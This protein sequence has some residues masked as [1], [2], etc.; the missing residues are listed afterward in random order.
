MPTTLTIRLKE[1]T[2]LAAENFVLLAFQ[3]CVDSFGCPSQRQFLQ[4]II[5]PGKADQ[6]ECICHDL[7]GEVNHKGVALIDIT[8]GPGPRP[9]GSYSMSIKWEQKRGEKPR[10]CTREAQHRV[11]DRLF[12]GGRNRGA[13]DEVVDDLPDRRSRADRLLDSRWRYPPYRE[14]PVIG[15]RCPYVLH[16]HSCRMATGKRFS[17]RRLEESTGNSVSGLARGVRRELVVFL[18]T[19]SASSVVPISETYATRAAAQETADWLNGLQGDGVQGGRN[20][21]AIRYDHPFRPRSPQPAHLC[22]AER[23]LLLT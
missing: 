18:P 11:F 19:C 5:R 13:T 6:A 2:N 3:R 7:A 12:S 23:L 21:P 15:P 10:G 22:M 20:H 17:D 14:A 1:L 9:A 8:E 4:E 16:S